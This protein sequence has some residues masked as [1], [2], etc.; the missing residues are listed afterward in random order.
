MKGLSQLGEVNWEMISHGEISSTH[1]N[2]FL[3]L[4]NLGWKRK[5]K[6][7]LLSNPND[8]LFFQEMIKNFNGE[9]RS[10]FTE[11]KINNQVI[12]SSTNLISGNAGFAFKIG[13]NPAYAKFSPGIINEI[14]LLENDNGDISNLEYIDSGTSGSNSYIDR[15]WNEKREIQTGIYIYSKFE[16]ITLPIIEFS[17]KIKKIIKLAI[18]SLW[19]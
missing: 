15:I 5:K 10:F 2:D 16:K 13:W 18:S 11:L 7:S 3:R 19:I 1:I 14:L 17:V 12:A 6:S 4:E 8:A 9:G